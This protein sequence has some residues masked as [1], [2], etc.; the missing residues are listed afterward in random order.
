MT[1]IL[2]IETASVTCSVAISGNEKLLALRESFVDKSHA[3]LVTVFIQELFEETG[4]KPADLDAISVSMGPGSYTGLRIGVSTAK[5]LAYGL[6]K[7]L[8]AVNTLKAMAW[9]LVNSPDIDLD[10]L[11]SDFYLSPMIDA[12]RMEVYTSLFDKDLSTIKEI[13]A[14]IID[15]QSFQAFLDEKPVFFF[16]NGAEKC[17]D[18]IQHKNARFIPGFHNSS[19]YMV[20]L[21][22]ESFQ[23]KK[24]EDVAYFEPFYLKD[25]IATTPKNKIL[26]PSFSGK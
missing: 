12:R 22:Y 26:G 16:G 9:G 8:I 5:G 19:K 7:R 20:S 13:S 23:L 2:H 24:F 1:N 21:A 17:E 3:A 15:E 11:R 18:I 25:F 10:D 6:G 4:L 14:E